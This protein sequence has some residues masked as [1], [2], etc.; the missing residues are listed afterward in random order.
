MASAHY[1]IGL[2]DDRHAL[3]IEISA[4]AWPD[5]ALVFIASAS[6]SAASWA[7]TIPQP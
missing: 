7:A 2:S 5:Q 3:T 4:V 6:A 1:L